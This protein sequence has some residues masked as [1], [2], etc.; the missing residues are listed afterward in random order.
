MNRWAF[1]VVILAALVSGCMTNQTGRLEI[2]DRF[3]IDTG[4]GDPMFFGA[5]LTLRLTEAPWFP[6]H[7]L[8]G[9]ALLFVIEGGRYSGEYVA[10]TSRV[11]AGLEDHLMEH[12]WA[13][14][15]V[16]RITN[17][18]TSFDGGGEDADPI[19]MAAVRSINLKW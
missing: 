9:K 5:P 16:H 15:V 12:G 1:I 14:V 10:L 18:T 19:G 2:G 17:P 3:L 11:L 8:R 4:D 7:V 6:G 13:S